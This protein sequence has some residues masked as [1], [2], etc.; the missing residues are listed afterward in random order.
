MPVLFHH[1]RHQRNV[2]K[3]SG[4]TNKPAGDPRS[5]LALSDRARG[6]LKT[7]VE[8]H[9]REGQPVASGRLARDS[10]LELSPATVRNVMVDLEELGLIVSP[11]TSAGRVPTAKGYRVFIDSLLTVQPP[12]HS[13]MARIH[14]ELSS[15][16][17]VDQ[18]LATASNLL[19]GISKMAGVV[20]VPRREVAA[21][22]R[23]DFLPL[24]EKRVLAIL[25]INER[26][27]D[28]R[29]IHTPRQYGESELQEA[30]NRLN[31]L[32]AG[33]DLRAARAALLAEM[34]H[35]KE[36]STSLMQSALDVADKVLGHRA[37]QPDY[38]VAGQ[39]NLM[40]FAEL[41]DVDKLRMLFEAFNEKRELLSLLDACVTAQNMQVFVGEESGYRVLENCSVVTAPYAVDG[42][43]L[44]V[45]GVIGPTRMAYEKV[46]PLVDVTA[47]MLTQLLKT[48]E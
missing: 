7:L 2:A 45:L 41:S 3:K 11:H 24:S 16:Q 38:V 39:T 27:I 12:T 19:S 4:N 1:I 17:T 28:N 40:H 8:Q 33:N 29:I 48:P 13:E 47:K 22:K 44:G 31:A 34:H 10:G 9:I 25:V 32:L 36:S 23:I 42:Q 14:G 15:T 21:I 5:G 37:Q 26:E 6:L 46:I 18:M 43:T 35:L 30:A 20:M